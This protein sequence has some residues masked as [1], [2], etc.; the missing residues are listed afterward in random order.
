MENN[1]LEKNDVI[2]EEMET[3]EDLDVFTDT[4]EESSEE[5]TSTE[6]TSTEEKGPEKKSFTDEELNN[7]VDD[8]VKK[9]LGRNEDKIRKEY[10]SL[11]NQLGELETI[12]TNGLGVDNLPEA[13]NHLKGYYKE[14]GVDIPDYKPKLSDREE[15][16]IAE[17]ESN[18]IKNAGIEEVKAEVDRLAAIGTNKMTTREKMIF[19]NLASFRKTQ[20]NQ[21]RLKSIGVSEDVLNH[22][23]FNEFASKFNGNVDIT[24]IYSMWDK[25]QDK[26]PISR[27]GSMNNNTTNNKSKIKDYYSQKEAERFTEQDYKDNP[28]LEKVVINSMTKW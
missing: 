9:K 3:E 2:D 12:L 7:Y 8:I 21:S 10:K 17:Y 28:E 6:E 13:I 5:E 1:E 22:K 27:I 16:A 11:E 18:R 20:E 25:T 23:D 4:E 15:E 14:Q 26:E 24:E 19:M